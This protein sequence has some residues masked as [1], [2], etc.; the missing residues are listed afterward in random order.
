MLKSVLRKVG[1]AGHDQ[2]ERDELPEKRQLASRLTQVAFRL[3]LAI[4]TDVD[5]FDPAPLQ[6]GSDEQTTVAVARILLRAHEGRRCA[7]SELNE[8]SEALQ[9]VGRLRAAVVVDLP[10]GVVEL[11]SIGSPT[12][13]GSK[14]HV[15]DAVE[16]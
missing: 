12:E 15:R 13:L 14:E 10:I 16:L 7:S 2:P 4:A 9:E 8:S 6:G 5:H 3:E 11:P 1:L